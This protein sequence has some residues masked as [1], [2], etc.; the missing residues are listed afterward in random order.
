[1][2]EHKNEE[3]EFS[4]ICWKCEK[5]TFY[6]L[7]D[8]ISSPQ[9]LLEKETIHPAPKTDYYL[10]CENPQCGVKNKIILD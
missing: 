1:M 2:N 3:K 8:L 6:E 7:E 9:L 4:F 5:V 10:Y